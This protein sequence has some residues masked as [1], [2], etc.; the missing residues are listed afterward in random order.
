MISMPHTIRQNRIMH[1]WGTALS[2]P[3]MQVV[4]PEVE[5]GEVK[6]FQEQAEP[7]SLDLTRLFAQYK[8]ILHNDDYHW[9]YYVAQSL[10]KVVSSLSI[11][12]AWR[13]TIRAHITGKA[14]V[15]VSH[16][17]AAEFYQERLQSFGLTITIE[18]E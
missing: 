3:R 6:P 17:E 12:E 7:A 14:V 8:V 16:K 10:L 18:P 5:Q 1:P 13:I 9:A 4:E 11:Q 2:L 15:I